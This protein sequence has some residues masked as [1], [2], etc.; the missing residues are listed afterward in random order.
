[1][2][3]FVKAVAKTTVG[4]FVALMFRVVATKIIAVTVGPEGV[5]LLSLFRQMVNVFTQIG[6]FGSQTGIVHGLASRDKQL[7]TQFLASVVI[8]LLIGSTI[9]TILF[10]YFA[11]FLFSYLQ[12]TD[13]DWVTLTPWLIVPL[14]L[15]VL[16]VFF[17]GILNGKKQIGKLAITRVVQALALA[18]VAWPVSVL[19]VSGYPIAL[20]FFLAMG[21]LA[22]VFYSG[23]NVYQSG[24]LQGLTQELFKKDKLE[25]IV[26]LLKFSGTVFFSLF[27][28]AVVVLA[29]RMMVADIKGLEYAGY[30]DASWVICT[31]YLM[32]FTT[33]VVTYYFPAMTE[34]SS[35]GERYK[36]LS[37]AA[38]II[39]ITC[40]PLVVLLIELKPLLV[41]LLYSEKF[42][43]AIELLRWMLIGGFFNISSS[44]LGN[45]LLAKKELKVYFWKQLTVYSFMLAIA[46]YAIYEMQFLEGLAIAYF[47]MCVANFLFLIVFCSLRYKKNYFASFGVSWFIGLLLI[48]AASF[49]S[50]GN[51]AVDWTQI[52]FS[53]GVLLVF[54]V[55]IP[56]REERRKLI[57]RMRAKVNR[58]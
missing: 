41:T 45:L 51:Q 44:I 22:G 1:M 31:T 37:F 9:G 15:N 17:Q 10:L 47:I 18:V 5:G 36:L 39:T 13:N 14:L 30:F 34:L 21:A 11:P 58:S 57:N 24:I 2:K 38:T 20:I 29:M 25:D 56:S 33:S 23:Y 27:Y 4:T 19:T 55:F 54:C 16:L 35:E 3:S 53:L 7:H 8:L 52:V 12:N 26:P 50:W 42:L 6:T 40:V 48:I 32:F 49:V 43:P 28:V 46:Y